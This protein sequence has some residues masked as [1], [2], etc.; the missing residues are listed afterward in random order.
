[1]INRAV[2]DPPLQ[3]RLLSQ[4]LLLLGSL[5]LLGHMLLQLLLLQ[6]LLVR[7]HFGQPL[8]QLRLACRSLRLFKGGGGGKFSLMEGFIFEQCALKQ[9][10]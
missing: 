7:F 3:K 4:L 10:V 6:V 2:T 1:M 8:V 9:A 5:L